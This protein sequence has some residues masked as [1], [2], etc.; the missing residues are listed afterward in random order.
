HLLDALEAIDALLDGLEVGQGPAQPAAGHEELAGAEGLLTDDV[1]R[2]LLGTDEEDRLAARGHVG[3]EAERR[4]R[5]VDRLLQ[6]DD[7]DAV[8]GT[9]DVRLHLRVPAAGLVTEVH[10]RLEELAHGD[11]ALRGHGL[12]LGG[13]GLRRLGG[14]V[15]RGLGLLARLLSLIH[16]SGSFL[17]APRVD[18]DGMSPGVGLSRSGHGPEA[19]ITDHRHRGRSGAG[20]C[21]MGCWYSVLRIRQLRETTSGSLASPLQA[22]LA[23]VGSPRT[24]PPNRAPQGAQAPDGPGDDHAEQGLRRSPGLSRRTQAVSSPE[25]WH[26]LYFLPE[27]QGQGSLRPTRGPSRSMGLRGAAAAVAGF[28]PPA[29]EVA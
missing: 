22:E 5:H 23:R 16:G 24:A 2:L 27:P 20:V 8:A 17:H 6:V 3:H 7:V 14:D 15:L 11:A 12:G 13:L 10:A 25:P 28:A 26:F 1:L 18:P 29:P 19:R 4:P 9:E 21:V